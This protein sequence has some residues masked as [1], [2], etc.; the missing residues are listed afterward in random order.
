MMK[1]THR[2]ELSITLT[3]TF[4]ITIPIDSDDKK[5]ECEE[6]IAQCV[7]G[8]TFGDATSTSG[9]E[10]N[11][12]KPIFFSCLILLTLLFRSSLI[13]TRLILFVNV[14]I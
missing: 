1:K 10:V 13:K 3:D 6:D 4:L 5:D 14:L 2:Q 11:Y 12:R 9:C 8:D 7:S